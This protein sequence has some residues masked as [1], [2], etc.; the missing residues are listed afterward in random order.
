MEEFEHPALQAVFSDARDVTD[1]LRATDTLQTMEDGGMLEQDRFADFPD[2]ASEILGDSYHPGWLEAVDKAYAHRIG[3]EDERYPSQLI[4][5][6]HQAI[7]DIGIHRLGL[8]D[9]LGQWWGIS[10]H[11][12]TGSRTQAAQELIRKWDN[13]PQE[14][15]LGGRMEVPS[16]AV[17]VTSDGQFIDGPRKYISDLL[18]TTADALHSHGSIGRCLLGLDSN[19]LEGVRDF[20]TSLTDPSI[21]RQTH[22]RQ[23]IRLQQK[24]NHDRKHHQAR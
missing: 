11:H 24:R 5:Q 15:Y 13:A 20:L 4:D 16:A 18:V 6:D 3:D 2:T 21:T 19:D 23:A 10:P 14:G 17:L 22:I 7:Y 9:A 12:G 1:A 8:P